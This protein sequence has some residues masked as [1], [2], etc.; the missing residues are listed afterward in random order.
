MKIRK[1]K[2]TSSIQAIQTS[3]CLIL[4]S[5]FLFSFLIVPISTHAQEKSQLLWTK[6]ECKKSCDEI[7]FKSEEQTKD[8]ELLDKID[9]WQCYDESTSNNNVECYAPPL[10]LK[11][12]VPIGD[13]KT[14]YGLTDYIVTFFNW[15]IRAITVVAIIMIMIAG[16]MWMTA[17]GS[18]Q[19]ITD[20]KNRIKNSIVGLVLALG[21][22]FMLK[23]INPNLTDLSALKIQMVPTLAQNT[24]WC[25]DVEFGPNASS[26]TLEPV[27]SDS[28]AKWARYDPE[29][30]NYKNPPF[31]KKEQEEGKVG[32]CGIRYRVNNTENICFG[33]TCINDGSKS[34]REESY[35]NRACIVKGI[36]LFQCQEGNLYGTF[37]RKVGGRGIRLFA[38]FKRGDKKIKTEIHG[39]TEGSCNYYFCGER[40]S[41]SFNLSYND[42][43]ATDIKEYFNKLE[44]NKEFLGYFLEFSVEKFGFD[45]EVII[46]SDGKP[47]TAVGVEWLDINKLTKTEADGLASIVI[48]ETIKLEEIEKGFDIKEV[49]LP[50]P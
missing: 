6:E 37:N 10:A 1:V 23:L 31:T 5:L 45:P 41:R 27:S 12:N 43:L 19:M 18:E 26:I 13:T 7:K 2:N 17:A 34:T 50:E 8:P 3:S 44:K 4:I 15:G 46:G 24:F 40:N 42:R 32:G 16:I 38:I 11:L 47:L 35:R 33:N 25:K 21:S 48:K 9:S 22:V 20:S 14:V 30:P 36:E 29:N 28:R 39:T 49:K